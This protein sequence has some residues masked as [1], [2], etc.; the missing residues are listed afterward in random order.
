MPCSPVGPILK[1]YLHSQGAAHVCLSSA[2]NTD[3]EPGAAEALHQTL[4][5]LGTDGLDPS[6][7]YRMPVTAGPA[8]VPCHMHC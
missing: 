3:P 4:G 5:D 2:W 1:L 8:R 6:H 7:Y